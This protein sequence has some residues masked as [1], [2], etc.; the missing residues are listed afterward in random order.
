M[1]HG[2]ADK[3]HVK[4]AHLQ[5]APS[6]LA[7]Y[8][9]SFGQ[10]LIQ[11]KLQLRMLG[12][13]VFDGVHTFADALAELLGFGSELLIGKLLHGGFEGVD[14]SDPRRETL[15]FPFVT[16]TEDG[17]DNFVEQCDIP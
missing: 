2:A 14:L 15:D 17:G 11:N 4:M 8:C 12:V 10:E 3:L 16:G 6:S 5:H 7:N 13:F 9:K 1:Q